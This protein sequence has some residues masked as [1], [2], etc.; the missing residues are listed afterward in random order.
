METIKCARCENKVMNGHPHCETCE[1][2][3]LKAGLCKWCG[4]N[5]RK[6]SRGKVKQ[7]KYCE[8]CQKSAIDATVKFYIRQEESTNPKFR[9]PEARENTRETKFG[10][11]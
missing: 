9:S 2:A 4:E 3:L 10:K 5:A 7:S 8:S 11:D 1:C 6:P